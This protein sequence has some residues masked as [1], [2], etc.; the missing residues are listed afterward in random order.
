MTRRSMILL[1]A[2]FVAAAV[3][4]TSGARTSHGSHSRPLRVVAIGDSLP[5]GRFDCNYCSTFVDRFGKALARVTHRHVIV[6]NLSEHTGIDSAD[7][8]RQLASSRYLRAAVAAADAITITIG[9]NDT[10]WN[11]EHDPCDG[12]ASGP[13]V[14]WASY[15]DS[16]ANASAADY[17]TNLDAIMK[18]VRTLRGH[19]LTLIRV[20]DDYNDVIGDPTVPQPTA[21]P[22][23]KRVVDAY[24]AKTCA[25]AR[26]YRVDCIDTYHAFNGPDG[27]RDAGPLLAGDHTHPNAA[28]HRLIARLLIQDGFKPLVRH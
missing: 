2:A 9:H 4:T 12:A 19:K 20:T 1:T 14:D 7:L 25:V 6:R 10:P 8:R 22:A 23:S 24:A 3:C 18:A 13:N 26:T 11:S 27:L 21:V 16:C 28:G 17:G 5:Y 15:T